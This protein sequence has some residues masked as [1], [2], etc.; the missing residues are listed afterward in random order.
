MRLSKIGSYHTYHKCMR[1]LCDFGYI[2]YLPSHNPLKGSE[3]YMYNYDTSNEQAMHNTSGNIGTSNEQAVQPSINNNKHVNNK[4]IKTEHTNNENKIPPEK[5]LVIR[6]FESEKSNML[7]AQ[8]FYN[9]F[10]ANG[11]KVG[12]R[13]KMKNWKAAARNWMLNAVNYKKTNT[14][15]LKNDKNYGEPL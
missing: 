6:F 13:T 8:K 14:Q 2:K 5:K 11:W 10:E 15:N 3:I 9:Y 12:G 4:T 7:E 1:Q